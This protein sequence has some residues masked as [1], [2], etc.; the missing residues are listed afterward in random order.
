ML[1]NE[2][3]DVIALLGRRD[4]PTD[5]LEDYST[6]LGD[7]LSRQGVSLEK[8]RVEWIELGWIRGLLDLSRKAE[9]WRGRWVLLQFTS[10]SWSRRGFP[11]G[12]LA[13]MAIVRRRGAHTGVVFHEPGEVGGARWIDRVR[14]AC[15]RWVIRRLYK[16]VERPVFTD[17]LESVPSLPKNSAKAVFIPIGANLPAQ[18]RRKK[19]F[20][21][22]R[23]VEKTIAIYCL[24]DL[25]NRLVEL[26]DI[27]Q[28]VASVAGNG[29]KLKVMFLGRGTV[30]AQADI[31]RVFQ[32]IPVSV[33]NL[34]VQEAASV[35]RYL[36]A[37]DVMMCMRGRLFPRR[38]SALAGISCGVPIVAYAGACENS[39][40]AEAGVE[41]VPYRDTTAVGRA[42]DRL[43]HDGEHWKDLHRRSVRMHEGCFSWDAIAQ[44]FVASL[45]LHESRA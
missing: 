23:S 27:S 44:K 20:D 34:G 22:A 10:L 24:S 36:E 17:P 35:S 16:M 26:A 1:E 32:A 43:L 18:P 11:F 38:G 40:L 31:K 21:S 13:A 6:F 25:P 37:S 9:N 33:T 29:L 2:V 5:G 3:A 14:R 7:G 8:V 39:P 15:Q 28:A 45:G 42:L 30:A 12:A 19:A 4:V 41:L